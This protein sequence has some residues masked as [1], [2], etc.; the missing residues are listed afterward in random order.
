MSQDI[1]DLCARRYIE[2]Q[3]APTIEQWRSVAYMA[4]LKADAIQENDPE[5][6]TGAAIRAISE[7]AWTNYVDMLP[8]RDNS[9]LSQTAGV[10]CGW[11]GRKA[12]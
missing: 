7:A 11:F 1:L 10:L 5:S 12:A 9:D 3:A 6:V 8:Q 4:A 2:A